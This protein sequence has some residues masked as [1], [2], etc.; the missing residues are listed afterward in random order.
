MRAQNLLPIHW[1]FVDVAVVVL[2]L[3]GV[4]LLK[5]VKTCGAVED[6][7]LCWHYT[8][9]YWLSSLPTLSSTLGRNTIWNVFKGGYA[10]SN[11][12]EPPGHNRAQCLEVP[13]VLTLN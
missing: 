8:C 5:N 11:S 10:L 3:G 6:C 4:A 1:V 7:L 9:T 2:A 12:L 13:P